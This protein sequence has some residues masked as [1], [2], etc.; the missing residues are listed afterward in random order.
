M[1]ETITRNQV[2]QRIITIIVLSTILLL[3][4]NNILLQHRLGQ[5]RQQ[6]ESTRIE[7]EY[8]RNR[9]SEL[10]DRIEVITDNVGRA[11]VI[12]HESITTIQEVREQFKQIRTVYEDLERCLFSEYN[13]ES[14]NYSN[15]NN[16][17]K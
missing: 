16:S 7:L 1:N 12:L 11:N 15:N 13:A 10:T 3:L 14:N 4:T 6:L 17:N 2:F 9:E 5:V 8:A